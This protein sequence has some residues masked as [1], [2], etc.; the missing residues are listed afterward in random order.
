[1]YVMLYFMLFLESCTVNSII[2][3]R[4]NYIAVGHIAIASS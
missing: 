4:A 3:I 1:M 2:I